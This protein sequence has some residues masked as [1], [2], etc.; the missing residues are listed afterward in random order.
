MGHID[1]IF[2]QASGYG[3]DEMKYEELL[4][5]L[6]TPSPFDR[7]ELHPDKTALL[8]IDMQAIAGIDHMLEEATRQGVS[9]AD[10]R[11]A[12]ADMDGRIKAA[13]IKAGRVLQAFRERDMMIVHTRIVAQSPDCR[14][15]GNLHRLVGL[16]IPPGHRYAE[17]LPG[18][19]PLEGELVLPKTCSSIF[20]GTNVDTILRN[21]GISTVVI[22]GFYSEQCITTAARDAADTGYYTFVVEDAVATT[23]QEIHDQAMD[24]IRELYAGLLTVDGLLERLI[25]RDGEEAAAMPGV[26]APRP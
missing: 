10:A 17:F 3:G 14:D 22:V 13:T 5:R 21:A 1:Q 4:D 9:E 11:E 2:R 24:H 7:L 25:E 23:T 26:E 6:R 16:L 15:V 8:L 20:T 12:L 19:E 18:V